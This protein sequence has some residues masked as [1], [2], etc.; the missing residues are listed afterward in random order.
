[1]EMFLMVAC[2]SLFGLAVVAAAFGAATEPEQSN[3]KTEIARDLVIT[4]PPARFFTD[5]L[6]TPLATQP[7]VPIEAILLQIENHGRLE[8][9]AAESFLEAPTSA[10]LHSR[11]ISPLIH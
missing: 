5:N 4:A 11:T 7:R 9:A 6:V 3:E 1:M 10:L 2:M 8:R